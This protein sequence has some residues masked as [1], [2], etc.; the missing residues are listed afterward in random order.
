MRI[1]PVAVLAALSIVSSS[2][3]KATE[4]SEVSA[5]DYYEA[6]YFKGALDNPKISRLRHDQQIS[7]IA[8]DLKVKPKSL[9]QAIA[10]VEATC[11]EP[12][13]I[14]RVAEKA[15]M[16]GADKTRVKGRVFDILLNT[17][18]PKHVVAYVRWQAS[19]SKDV[20]KEASTI[21]SLIAQETPFV[22]TLSLAA[23]HP[24]ANKESK[25]AVWSA[26][27]SAEAMKKIQKQRIDDYAD[28]L[29]K[30]LFEGVEEKSF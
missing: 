10:K 27:I 9:Q 19:S 20:V 29:Y 7:A 16:K 8:R 22:S 11:G 15:V 23:I 3:A 12:E 24:K 6:A 1:V 13:Q 30:G 28:R 4:L 18:E 2:S 21:A 26:K 17:D 25:D 14:G 5:Q